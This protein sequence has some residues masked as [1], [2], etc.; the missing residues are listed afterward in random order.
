M[1]ETKVRKGLHPV[2]ITVCPREHCGSYNS[3]TSSGPVEIEDALNAGHCTEPDKET[4]SCARTPEAADMSKVK[5]IVGFVITKDFLGLNGFFRL[6]SSRE[7]ITSQLA[8][9]ELIMI[10]VLNA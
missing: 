10:F 9:S 5:S 7:S 2:S 1:L 4:Q 3:V 6:R 8:N